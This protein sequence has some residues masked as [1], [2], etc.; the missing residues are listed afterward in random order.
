MAREKDDIIIVDVVVI[1]KGRTT[2]AFKIILQK[3][4]VITIIIVNLKVTQKMSIGLCQNSSKEKE[5][6]SMTSLLM[7]EWSHMW[8]SKMMHM[9]DF[10]KKYDENVESNV[11]LKDDVFD[12]LD[13]ITYLEANDFF[14]NRNWRLIIELGNE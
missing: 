6:K 14:G 11:A 8:L 4:R 10:L 1:T 3:E 2:W 7:P 5:I 9:Q 12:G 13:D